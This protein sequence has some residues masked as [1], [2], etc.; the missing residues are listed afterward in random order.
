MKSGEHDAIAITLLINR[1]ARV[2]SFEKI[3]NDSQRNLNLV[4]S[5]ENLF[6][7]N[8]IEISRLEAS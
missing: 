8:N 1:A 5:L 4:N 6:I 2:A 3:L 7:K